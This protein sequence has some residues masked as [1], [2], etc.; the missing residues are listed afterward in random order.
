VG[1]T[2]PRRLRFHPATGKAWVQE[3]DKS[4]AV[5]VSVEEENYR[6]KM[7]RVQ[8]AGDVEFF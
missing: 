4:S 7:A 6:R 3:L 1:G 2:A 8:P 5:T